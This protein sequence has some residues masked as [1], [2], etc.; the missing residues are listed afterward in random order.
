MFEEWKLMFT[1]PI[2][3]GYDWKEDRPSEE[4]IQCSGGME[5]CRTLIPSWAEHWCIYSRKEG[6]SWEV[7]EETPGAA[8]E[9]YELAYRDMEESGLYQT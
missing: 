8:D 4:E 7:Q 1:S 3:D 2:G 5:A 9:L 6:N